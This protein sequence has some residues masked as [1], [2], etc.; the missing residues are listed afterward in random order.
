MKG[1][2]NCYCAIFKIFFISPT[3]F[4]CLSHHFFIHLKYFYSYHFIPFLISPHISI[5]SRCPT[6]Y[7]SSPAILC[8]IYIS[9]PLTIHLSPFPAFFFQAILSHSIYF[10]IRQSSASSFF[11]SPIIFLQ[12][13]HFSISFLLHF[14][15]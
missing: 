7:L 12:F 2:L 5:M 15:L 14:D 3:K 1:Q 9:P 6:P 13:S 4:V 11:T 8:S 10:A